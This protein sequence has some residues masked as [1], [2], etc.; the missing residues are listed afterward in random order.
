MF[1]YE[2]L[3]HYT[4]HVHIKACKA[5]QKHS[6]G[7]NIKG[8]P[9]A[10]KLTSESVIIKFRENTNNT[11]SCFL[12]V[13]ACYNTKTTLVLCWV[14]NANDVHVCRQVHIYNLKTTEDQQN[15]RL[16]TP[17]LNESKES[18]FTRC[19]GSQYIPLVEVVFDGTNRKL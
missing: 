12:N 6:V 13:R 5:K 10:I 11:F 14:W 19:C 8:C 7:A 4:V 17:S 18:A 3:L 2:Y 15:P 9:A 16:L 1:L